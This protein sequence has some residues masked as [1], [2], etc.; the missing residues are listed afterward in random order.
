ML[1]IWTIWIVNN[2]IYNLIT[3]YICLNICFAQNWQNMKYNV[4]SQ[5]DCLVRPDLATFSKYQTIKSTSIYLHTLT[6][7]GTL[8]LHRKL[9][10]KN[11]NIFSLLLK[12]NPENVFLTFLSFNI[13]NKT[14]LKI[15]KWVC[16]Q[17]FNSY[18]RYKIHEIDK[19]NFLPNIVI[20]NPV[21]DCAQC[22]KKASAWYVMVY[23]VTIRYTWL[24]WYVL[25]CYNKVHK[26]TM[27]CIV[28]I[29]AIGSLP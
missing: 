20:L 10:M 22:K 17:Y 5:V 19:N 28:A 25:Y 24:Q 16:K 3:G 23:I 4:T 26:V 2:E 6:K 21:N 11:V 9:K 13:Y 18:K 12:M 15:I 27:I 14:S 8:F 1:S 29:A 7:I